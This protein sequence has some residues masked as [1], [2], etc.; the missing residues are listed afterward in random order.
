MKKPKHASKVKSAQK[1]GAKRNERKRK[2]E[3]NKH[4]HNKEKKQLLQAQQRKF[5]QYMSDLIG[6]Q[7]S[8]M[9]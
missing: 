9:E 5:N 3:E 8:A 7:K 1:R 4:V 2:T 6:Q